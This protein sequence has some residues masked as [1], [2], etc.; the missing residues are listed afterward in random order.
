MLDILGCF[1]VIISVMAFNMGLPIA[2]SVAGIL[3][4]IVWLVVGFNHKLTGLIIL[5]CVLLVTNVM[6]LLV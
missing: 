5:N 2:G 6:G 4:S 3:G 1:L